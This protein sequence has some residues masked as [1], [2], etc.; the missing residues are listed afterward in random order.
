VRTLKNDIRKM[1]LADFDITLD[2]V[3]KHCHLVQT[4][5]LST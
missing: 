3:L 5:Q 2:E 4:L 1:V